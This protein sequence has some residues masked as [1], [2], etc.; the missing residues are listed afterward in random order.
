M[1]YFPAAF[2]TKLS[3]INNHSKPWGATNMCRTTTSTLDIHLLRNALGSYPT[4]VAVVT[5]S[6]RHRAPVGMT[7][8]SFTSISLDPPLLGWCIDRDS[9]S[10]VDFTGATGFSI[11]VLAKHQGDI[12]KRFATRSADKFVGL[13]EDP[14]MEPVIPESCALFRCRMYR[15]IPLGDHVMLVGRVTQFER[16]EKPPLVFVGGKFR[17]LPDAPNIAA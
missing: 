5:A 4:G 10:F 12:A 6:G 9:A 3:G 1:Q 15:V 16:R 7:I 14:A 2:F 13:V 8:N 11:S 17:Q